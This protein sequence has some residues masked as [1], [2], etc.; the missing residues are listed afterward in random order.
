MREA[1][2]GRQVIGT[3]FKWAVAPGHPRRQ[4]RRRPRLVRPRQ[5]TRPRAVGGGSS[6]TLAMARR[7][8]EHF[9]RPSPRFSSGSC[10]SRPALAKSPACGPDELATDDKGAR[11]DLASGTI[12]EQE[13]AGLR[14]SGLAAEI[15]CARGTSDML[16]TSESGEPHISGSV[17]QQLHDTARPDCRS[18][19]SGAT[20][21]GVRPRR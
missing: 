21:C 9:H 19:S 18:T 1:E 6:R 3:M 11:S 13:S 16:F 14:L 12:E 2:H 15:L 10:V 17:S 5:T 7:Q 8:S 4:S 20:I